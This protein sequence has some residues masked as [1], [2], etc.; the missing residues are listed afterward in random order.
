MTMKKILLA[1][2]CGFAL[3]AASGPVLADGHKTQMQEPA[4]VAQWREAQKQ[5]HERWVAHD[6]KMRAYLAEQAKAFAEK[7]KALWDERQ[8]VYKELMEAEAASHKATREAF[9]KRMTKGSK[10]DHKAQMEAQRAAM[11]ARQDAMEKLF[12]LE[13][14]TIGQYYGGPWFHHDRDPLG[15][16]DPKAIKE[17]IEKRRAEAKAWLEKER[18]SHKESQERYRKA[19]EAWWKGGPPPVH[20]MQP[21]S[22]K[23]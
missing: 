20:A 14:K 5:A 15:A 6:K 13:Q 10:E 2:A 12:G 3:A 9:Q 4:W 1:A 8:K 17:A 23:K 19:V 11:K 7:N 16:S 22:E 18:K 21:K